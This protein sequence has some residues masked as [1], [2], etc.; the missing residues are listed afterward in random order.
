MRKLLYFIII[1]GLTAG[2]TKNNNFELSSPEKHTF[3]QSE[4]DALA[5][6]QQ[7][8]NFFSSHEIASKI[9]KISYF[10]SKDKAYAFVYY[11]SDKGYSNV[12]IEKN[13]TTSKD[14]TVSERITSTKC[15]GRC[16]ANPCLLEAHFDA[17]GNCSYAECT[18]TAC[19]MEIVTNR[20]P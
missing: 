3:F 6:T 16:G 4:D 2:C 11:Y 13:F 5:K 9:D 8:L 14:G 10:D 12:L 15:T 18:C 20:V 17:N 7:E 1:I 19:K